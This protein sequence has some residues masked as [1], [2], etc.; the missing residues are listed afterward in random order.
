MHTNERR[1]EAL[2]LIKR[3]HAK[4]TRAGGTVPDW[5][6]LD[7]VSRYL[8]LTLTATSEGTADERGEI[9]LAG[10]GHDA[11][12]D[13]EVSGDELESCFGAHGLA[14][15]E[16]MTNRFGDDHPKEYVEQVVA[17][18]EGVRL[19]KYSDLYDNVTSVVYGMSQLGEKWTEE[20]FLP[21]VRP[22]FAAVSKTEFSAYPRA[23]A[24]LSEMVRI[25][26]A[27]LEDEFERFYGR[28][29]NA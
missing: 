28:K 24:Q 2:R 10:L 13:T 22:M 9:V 1:E 26:M 29:P 21:I 8:E 25:S 11:L 3:I 17:A 6:H 23:A 12:E 18:E 27:T 16:G 20:F 14:L 4:Q 7:R 15:I 5:H 19:I